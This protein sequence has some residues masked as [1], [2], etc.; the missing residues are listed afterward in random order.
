M[1]YFPEPNAVDIAALIFIAVGVFI[2][3]RRG[4]SG[5]L[6]HLLSIAAAFIVGL[7]FHQPIGVWLAEHTRLSPQSGRAMAFFLAVVVAMLGMVLA[8]L[9]VKNIMKVVIEKEADKIG[10]CI[11]GFVRSSV[12]VI[13]VFLVMNMWPHDYLNRQFGEESIIG[14]VV[15]KCMPSLRSALDDM[16]SDK[17]Q[18]T[19]TGGRGSHEGF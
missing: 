8:R 16:Q 14:S 12:I 18:R 11:A 10:G 19:A 9:A 6:A 1:E 2:G 17:E 4:L 13:A 15:L 3:L 7:S 5:E